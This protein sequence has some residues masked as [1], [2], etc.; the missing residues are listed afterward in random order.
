[1]IRIRRQSGTYKVW[2]QDRRRGELDVCR[3]EYTNREDATL[4]AAQ[5]QDIFGGQIVWG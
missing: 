1:M 5:L 3:F 2:R 4:Y